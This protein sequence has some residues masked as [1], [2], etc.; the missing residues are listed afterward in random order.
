MSCCDHSSLSSTEYVRTLKLQACHGRGGLSKMHGASSLAP[1]S[2]TTPARCMDREF[3][4]RRPVVLTICW[5]RIVVDRILFFSF[6]LKKKD[7]VLQFPASSGLLV[8]LANHASMLGSAASCH[9]SEMRTVQY[10]TP[11]SRSISFSITTLNIDLVLAPL[12]GMDEFKCLVT[13]PKCPAQSHA[14]H[15]E[16]LCLACTRLVDHR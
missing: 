6:F 1:C 2:V 5:R 3:L 7:S 14:S 11:S 10:S 4:T 9:E 12:P 15:K 13:G 16:P 8:L